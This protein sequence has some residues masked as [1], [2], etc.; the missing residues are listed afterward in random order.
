MKSIFSVLILTYIY[1]CSTYRKTAGKGRP[2]QSQMQQVPGRIE[3]EFY[4][5]GGEGIAY[6]DS[7]SV[8]NGSGRL[9][10]AN[11]S[12]LNEFRMKEGVD[13]SYTKKSPID[14][15][16][17]NLVAPEMN[18][19]YVGWTKPGEWIRYSIHVNQSGKYPIGL[20]YTANG[21]VTISFD[22]DWKDATGLLQI[23]STY[24]DRDTV[25]WRQWHHW[26]KADSIGFLTLKKGIH[27][28]T[29]HIVTNGNINLDYLDLE[30]VEP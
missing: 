21:K 1:S 18:Q 8:N 11:G 10:P 5:E 25:T 12:F 13:I 14:D 28:L 29:L 23:N 9:N 7:D 22:L 30:K 27:V 17:Y 16:P 19:F 2:W 3:F 4:D 6:H 20:L 24:D 15:N 26:N